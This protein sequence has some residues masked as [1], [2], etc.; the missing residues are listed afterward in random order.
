M[1]PKYKH[2][3][4]VDWFRKFTLKERLKILFGYNIVVAFRV[5]TV[6]ACGAYE[7][8]IKAETTKNIDSKQQ[9]LEQF[10][11]EIKLKLSNER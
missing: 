1:P 2:V 6:N 5:V 10:E 7:P 8:V 3:L 9:S 4:S 11:N